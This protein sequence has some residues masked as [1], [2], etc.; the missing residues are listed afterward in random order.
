[1]LRITKLTDYGIVLLVQL[2]GDESGSS[3]NARTMAEATS[4]PL[5]VVSKI[6]K[7]LAQGGL[8]NSQRGAKGGYALARR[9]E[10]VSV[11]EIIDA[12]EGPIALMECSVGPG[13]C[14][15]ETNCQVRNPWQRINQ[16]ILETLKHVTLRELATPPQEEILYLEPVD[17][18]EEHVEHN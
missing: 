3:K 16:A 5:P 17:T 4:L 2:A 14:E 6:L 7:S 18:G 8:L 13:H 11:A 12:L 10:E 9:P 1:M 15:Q